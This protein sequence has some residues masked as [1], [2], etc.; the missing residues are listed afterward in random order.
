MADDNKKINKEIKALNDKE[1]KT[2]IKLQ[3][4]F[5]GVIYRNIR[6]SVRNGVNTALKKDIN[7]FCKTLVDSG[8]DYGSRWLDKSMKK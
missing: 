7:K 2:V 5:R 1:K 3:K 8:L 6:K 4:M